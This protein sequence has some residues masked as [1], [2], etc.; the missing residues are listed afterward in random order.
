VWMQ[1]RMR[2]MARQAVREGTELPP[3][4]WRYLGFWV[5]LGIPA[6]FALVIVFYLMTAKPM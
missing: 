2:D 6:F 4:Y 5:V 1:I 3:L